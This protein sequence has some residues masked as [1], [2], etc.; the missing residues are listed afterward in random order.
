M[1]YLC[2]TDYEFFCYIWKNSMQ[3]KVLNYVIQRY[4][5]KENCKEVYWSVKYEFKNRSIECIRFAQ[6]LWSLKNAEQKLHGNA[7]FPSC[8]FLI[9]FFLQSKYFNIQNVVTYGT[10]KSCYYYFTWFNLLIVSQNILSN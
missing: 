10:I 9:A 5:Y 2:N 4:Y 6:D 3:E 1:M 7:I 8:Y